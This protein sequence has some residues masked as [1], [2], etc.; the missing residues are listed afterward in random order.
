MSIAGETMSRKRHEKKVFLDKKLRPI[1]KDNNPD[2]IY[3]INFIYENEKLV[4]VSFNS[5]NGKLP[6]FFIEEKIID[7][8]LGLKRAD[9]ASMEI[10]RKK[11][12]EK[13]NLITLKKFAFECIK[14]SA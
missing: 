7:R 6:S 3:T 14:Y 12:L 5:D 11:S 1:A 8:Y 13:T 2:A 4:E 9:D 10:L